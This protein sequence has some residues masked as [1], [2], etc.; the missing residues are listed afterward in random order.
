VSVKP[1]QKV[2]GDDGAGALGKGNDEAAGERSGKS[3]KGLLGL[4]GTVV[5]RGS[6]GVEER[7]RTVERERGD[8][9]AVRGI[10]KPQA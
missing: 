8:R 10:E 1:K 3:R 9:P 4:C 6:R 7:K 5:R 2:K